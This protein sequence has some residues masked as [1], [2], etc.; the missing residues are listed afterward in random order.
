MKGL[1]HFTQVAFAS[2]G[3]FIAW[4]VGGIDGYV[5]VLTIFVVADYL[6]GVMKSIVERRLSSQI[7]AKGIFKKALIFILIGLS[8]LIDEYLMLDFGIFRTIVVFFYISN[9]G[10]SILENAS[11]IGLPIPVRLKNILWQ[12]GDKADKNDD[13]NRS[14][15]K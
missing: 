5:Y 1:W 4:F 6:T 2:L 9:E 15:A 7:G 13:G 8:N 3:G 11:A 12:L 14:D 10:I